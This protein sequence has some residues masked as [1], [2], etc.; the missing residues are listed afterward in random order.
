[1]LGWIA[2]LKKSP[3]KRGLIVSLLFLSIL[4]CTNHD[5]RHSI[6]DNVNFT[7]GQHFSTENTEDCCSVSY[8]DTH[9]IK[10]WFLTTSP[11]SD[12]FNKIGLFALL[13]LSLFLLKYA[14]QKNEQS[15]FLSYKRYRKRA[16][17]FQQSD[18]YSYLFSI[19]ILNPKVF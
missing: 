13:G 10:T 15:L 12:L 9:N 7:S 18:P 11:A 3:L 1:M 16:D 6:L 2:K 5:I 19:G 8:F 17:I 14:Q 4:I